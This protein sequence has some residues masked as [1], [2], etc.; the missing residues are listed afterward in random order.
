MRLKVLL[1]VLALATAALASGGLASSTSSTGTGSVF[2]SNPVQSLGDESLTDQKDSDAAVPADA[3]QS[4]QLRN[5]DGSGYL[6]GDYANVYSSTGRRAFS[7]TNTFTYTRHQDQFEQVMA[8]YWITQ[9]QRYIHSLGFGVTR[10]GIDNRPQ[11]VRINQWGVDNSFATDHPKDEMRF[12][13]GGV[14]DAEDAEVIVHE[15]GHAIHFS[16]NFSFASEEAGAI[17]EG[18]GDY[19]A[20]TVSDVV[21]QALGV[22]Q[23]E[24]LPCVADW[25][26]TSYTRGVPHCLRR[27]DE[28][29]S[30]P[31]D[32]DGEVHDDGQIW[33]RALWG[34]RQSLG[35]VQADTIILQGSFDFP[36][37]TMPDLAN[38]T[39]EAARQLYGDGV[40]DTVRQVFVSRGIL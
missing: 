4:V 6:Q 25:D 26:S 22:P 35:N 29:L 37:T 17:S 9:A 32:L 39:V 5:L 10:R 38:R 27:V 11:A 24:P 15:Y 33:S 31:D 34:I 23:L 3:Y 40:A 18:F 13:K 21:D 14:D 16:Q 7:P 20:V 12:G 1:G 30:Y 8:Y 36:G 2:A 19:W 28:D